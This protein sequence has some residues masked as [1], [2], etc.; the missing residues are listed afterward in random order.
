MHTTFFSRNV[1]SLKNVKTLT[2]CFLLMFSCFF[3]LVIMFCA[4]SMKQS[5]NTTK[6]NTLQKYKH[7]MKDY[8]NVYFM[9]ISG[10]LAMMGIGFF[11][12]P[13]MS[14][15]ANTGDPVKEISYIN[16]SLLLVFEPLPTSTV[17]FWCKTG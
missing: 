5:I 1:F 11:S 6:Q 3:Y 10:T 9:Q 14:T 17:S 2:T 8:Q 15:E 4:W 12:C 7:F 16:A 13:G